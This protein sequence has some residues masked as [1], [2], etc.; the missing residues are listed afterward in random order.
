M[1]V[2]VGVVVAEDVAVVL[3]VLVLDVVAVDVAEVVGVVTS[4]VLKAP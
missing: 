1:T 4:H 2:V 3:G